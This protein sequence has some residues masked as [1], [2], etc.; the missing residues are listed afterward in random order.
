[1]DPADGAGADPKA[2]TNQFPLHGDAPSRILPGEA[3][4]KVA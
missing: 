1:M 3:Q 2:E 4:D